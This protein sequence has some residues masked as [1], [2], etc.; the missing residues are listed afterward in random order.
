[1]ALDLTLCIV[2]AQIIALT[3]K[4]WNDAAYA[5]LLQFVPGILAKGDMEEQGDRLVKQLNSDVR[6]LRRHYNFITAQDYVYDTDRV[7][8]SLDFVL[9][10][11]AQAM[12]EKGMQGVLW[13]GGGDICDSCKGVQGVP[14][15]LYDREQT[16]RVSYFLQR[17]DQ[18]SVRRH[19]SHDQMTAEGV[20]KAADEIEPVI[21]Y[22]N[23]VQ[24]LFVKAAREQLLVLK[25][26]D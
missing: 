1:M 23:S 15:K 5:E 25:V 9:D 8:A 4:A 7:S 20:Y 26:I 13:K 2:P 24:A 11:V 17:I 22:F 3:D 6:S 16:G 12:G 18:D 14:L 21:A 19:Y 10:R